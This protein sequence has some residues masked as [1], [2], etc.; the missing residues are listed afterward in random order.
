MRGEKN[1]K[2]KKTRTVK[3]ELNIYRQSLDVRK[4]ITM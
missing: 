3:L 1:E 4:F 2:K